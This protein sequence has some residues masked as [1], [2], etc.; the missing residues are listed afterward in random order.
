MLEPAA[1]SMTLAGWGE[2]E[3]LTGVA[4]LNETTE[5]GHLL[6]DTA[7]HV[8]P[9]H[10]QQLLTHFSLHSAVQLLQSSLHLQQ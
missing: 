8:S 4:G 3:G 1:S 2:G 5:L 7:L 9:D 10:L 6:H